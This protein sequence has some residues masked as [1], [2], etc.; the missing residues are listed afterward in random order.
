MERRRDLR[1]EI[2]LQC[3][4]QPIGS[5]QVIDCMTINLSRS[6]ALIRVT[7]DGYPAKLPQPGDVLWAEVPLPAHRQFKQRCLALK[8]IAVRTR[9]ENGGWLVALRFERIQFAN[10]KTG[11]APEA[12]LAV[13]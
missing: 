2:R 10:A 3:R 1:F 11:S 5:Q 9:E 6:G 13:M 12:S 4:V 8:A 7:P